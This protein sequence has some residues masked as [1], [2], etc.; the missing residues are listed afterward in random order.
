MIF[1]ILMEG[2]NMEEKCFSWIIENDV[3]VKE[4]DKSVVE[5]HGTG[6]PHQI[7][8]YWDVEFISGGEKKAIFLEMDN[9][10]Y[11]AQ[12][13]MRRGRTRLFWHSDFRDAANLKLFADEEKR[14]ILKPYMLFK[15]IEQYKYSV[16]IISQGVEFEKAKTI[17]ENSSCY[18]EGRR[19]VYYTTKYERKAKCRQQAIQIQGCK[20]AICGFDFQAVY[21]KLGEGFTEI[22]HKKPLSSIDEEIEVNPETDLVPVCSNCHRMLHRRRD[23][24][25][26]IEE[27]KNIINQQ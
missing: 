24:I 14:A 12:I 20:C 27:L 16:E 5:H 2:E 21:G 7:R 3:A 19:K 4:I 15:R 17:P 22:H 18:I 11:M 6:I 8:K 13:E 23:R 9:N 10:N 26:T 25:I 1:L